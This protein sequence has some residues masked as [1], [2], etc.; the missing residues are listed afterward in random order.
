MPASAQHL[1]ETWQCD[2]SRRLLLAQQNAQ[3][4]SS[5]LRKNFTNKVNS[6]EGPVQT[7]AFVLLMQSGSSELNSSNF[8]DEARSGENCQNSQSAAQ[9]A[10]FEES[11]KTVAVTTNYD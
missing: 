8:A 10:E 5:I 7:I 2:E 1:V 3:I 4:L 9:H 11:H 6:L